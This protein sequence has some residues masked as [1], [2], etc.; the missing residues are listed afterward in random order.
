MPPTTPKRKTNRRELTTDSRSRFLYFY[1]A[2]E[3]GDTLKDIYRR[4]D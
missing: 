3:L 1:N 2:R 4:I